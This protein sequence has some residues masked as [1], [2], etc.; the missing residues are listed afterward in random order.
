MP[1]NGSNRVTQR[2][3]FEAIMALD[4]KLST[5]VDAVLAAVN[6]NRTANAAAFGKLGQCLESHHNRLEALDGPDGR[7]AGL[8]RSET[9]WRALTAFLGALAGAFFGWLTGKG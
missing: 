8:E 1:P 9:R 5:K 6:E 4:S 2:Q 7:V 3:H